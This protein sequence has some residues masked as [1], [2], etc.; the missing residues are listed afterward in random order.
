MLF[1]YRS[2]MLDKETKNE[3][4]KACLGNILKCVINWLDE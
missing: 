1:L 3:A 2:G 4:E